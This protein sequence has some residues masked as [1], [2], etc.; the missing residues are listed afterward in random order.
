MVLTF[1]L[2]NM[3]EYEEATEIIGSFCSL[4]IPYRGYS[5]GT[6]VGDYGIELV[7]RLTNG[8]EIVV[9]RDEVIIYD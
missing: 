9:Y 1:K 3:Y 6:V 2:Y 5:D 8:K 4:V 7:V